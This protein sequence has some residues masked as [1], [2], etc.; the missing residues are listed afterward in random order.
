MI[1]SFD[2]LKQEISTL[3]PNGR[4]VEYAD[5]VQQLKIWQR[6]FNSVFIHKCNDSVLDFGSGA[7]W[8]EYVFKQQFISGSFQSLDLDDE[9]VKK[10]F[11]EYAKKLGN[12]V[13]YYDGLSIPCEDGGYNQIVFK[14]SIMK[15][16]AS[17]RAIVL[18][19]LLRVSTVGCHW[20]IAPR[21]MFYR[22]KDYLKTVPEVEAQIVEKNI[23]V[24]PW[25]WDRWRWN[26]RSK[27]LVTEFYLGYK[28]VNLYAKFLNR[29]RDA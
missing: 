4:W 3:S 9:E 27:K 7:T 18:K 21:S 22:F 13:V 23:T 24:I 1:K 6:F 8:A 17:S 14:A 26:D 12:S 20:Y 29:R 2:S 28:L 10:V 19:E 25:T 15:P 11:G 16:T 5:S